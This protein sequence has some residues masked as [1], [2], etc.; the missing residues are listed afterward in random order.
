MLE[1]KFKMEWPKV[2]LFG[3]SITRRSTDVENGC[4]GSMIEYKI[5]SFFDLDPRGFEGYNSKW[6]LQ[7]MPK[8]FPRSYLEKVQIFIPFFGHNDSWENTFPLHVPVE[9]YEANMRA[10]VKYLLDNGLGKSK[11]ILITPTW[12]HLDK[13][14]TFLQGLGYPLTKKELGSAKKY[15]EAILRIA[16]D[17]QLDVLDFFDISSKYEPL[18]DLFCDGVHLSRTGAKLLFDNLMPIVEKKL[19]AA[20]EKPL[21]DMWHA[22]P[23]EQHEE[24]EPVLK[25]FQASQAKQ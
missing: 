17:E 14:T 18:G 12:F 11:I 9:Q 25:A 1:A 4:W 5:N 22:V 20:F 16:K 21:A 13:F 23:V 2:T 10:I 24:V 15:S 19:V 6:A 8:L 7:L 3:D